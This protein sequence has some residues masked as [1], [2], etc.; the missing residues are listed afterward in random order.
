[1]VQ[2]KAH[3]RARYRQFQE[4]FPFILAYLPERVLFAEDFAG[5]ALDDIDAI[6]GLIFL[7]KDRPTRVKPLVEAP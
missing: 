6:E 7:D 4:K 5:A 1:M 3:L 2:A